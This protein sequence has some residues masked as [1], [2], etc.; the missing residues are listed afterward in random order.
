MV[1]IL[2]PIFDKIDGW[3]SNFLPFPLQNLLWGIV[4][5]IFAFIIYLLFS[6]QSSISELKNKMKALRKKMFDSS[7]DDKSEY[8]SL[9]KQNLSLSFKLLSKIML[10]ALLS[11]IPVI[12]I[13]IWYDMNHSFIIP[14]FDDRVPISATPLSSTLD[15]QPNNLSEIDNKGDLYIRPKNINDE[16]SIF[17]NEVLIYSGKLF[18][19][20]IPFIIKKK[21]WN[22]LLSSPVGYITDD[23]QIE[24]IS[25]NYPE[26]I[27]FNKMPHI[28]NGWELFFF[29]GIFISALP[30]RII[31]KVQ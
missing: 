27:I 7:L 25:I 12:I 11:V 8:N 26:K 13:A 2:F 1:N 3:T 23:S 4:S 31:F 6:N 9:A 15:I 20:P 19:K 17:N 24:V 14:F 30:L 18:S 29:I 22:I 21:W 16:I 5:G 10:P 28:I